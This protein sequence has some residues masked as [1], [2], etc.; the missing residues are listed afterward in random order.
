LGA[1]L[2]LIFAAC[3]D[4]GVESTVTDGADTTT[5]GDEPDVDTGA[6]DVVTPPP[7][8]GTDTGD[9]DIVEPDPDVPDPDVPDVPPLPECG[10]AA[11]TLPE[12]LIE[13]QHSDDVDG[14]ATVAAQTWTSTD[15]AIP[16]ATTSLYEAMRFELEHPGKIHGFSIQYGVLPS[17]PK[18]PVV[19]GLYPDFGNNG[20][21]FWQKDPYWTGSLC[22]GEITAGEWATYVF[23][24]PI[25]AEH[26]MLVYVA[27]HR[28]GDDDA[29]ISFGSTTTN[30]DGSCGGWGDCNASL[31]MPDVHTF[32]SGGQGNYAWN[33]LS[34]PFQYDFKI[35]LYVEY[36]DD[37]SSDDG[38]FQPLEEGPVLSNRTAWG[39][40]D[41]DGDADIYTAN[42]KL[43]RNDD[44]VF[45][46]VTEASGVGAATGNGGVWGDFDNDGCLDLFVFREGGKQNDTL[47]RS[48]CDDTWTDIT[49]E[50]GISD[51]QWYNICGDAEYDHA[52]T[53]AA[54]WWD[55]DGDGLLDLYLANMICWSD[56]TF[57]ND[58]IWHNEGDNTFTEWTGKNGFP[59]Y[60]DT[61]RSS[62]GANPIDA[63]QDGDVDMLVNRYTLHQNAYYRNNGDGT[64]TEDGY[65]SNLHGK[66][67]QWTGSVHYGH[68]IGTAWGDIDND[69]DFD[70]IVAN[71]AHPRFFNFSNKTQVMINDGQGEW[72][73]TQGDYKYP[74][75]D[76]GVRFSE[77]HSVP[78]L[79]DYDQNGSLDLVITA[80]YSGRPTDFYWGQGDG[81]FK[82]DTYHSGLTL[83]GAWGLAQADYDHD[84]DLDL[85]T[86]AGLYQNTG[87]EKG[88]WLQARAIGNVKSNRAALG[89]T[90]RL[91]IGEA[92]RVG[93]VSGGNGQG[94]QDSPNVH[95]GL[96]ETDS[97]DSIEVDFPGGGTITYAGPFAVDQRIW[98]FEDGATHIGWTPP[99]PDTE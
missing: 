83:T 48:N 25:E 74:T 78:A 62:R 16:L 71:L 46:D 32:T 90:I 10:E 11:G 98:L 72:N 95:F 54:A 15:A 31:T 67:K 60:T 47:L 51:L 73:D 97:V 43:F 7:D 45:V 86:S 37:F 38:L 81:T 64:V 5:T 40:Y 93:Y 29:A 50:S 66:K 55:I 20:F 87:T 41:G 88:H 61:A 82:L 2:G 52:P 91:K 68:S 58:Q 33:G 4:D 89:A 18:M 28:E 30:A 49:K 12:G 70:V 19:A 39:D 9:E 22:S 53:P 23:D 75:G 79:G 92:T 80:T 26:P 65:E 27:H 99:V 85:A 77:T 6:E 84:G 96:G 56:Y 57:F 8:E 94:G 17:N 42:N 3:G 1:C 35:R 76:A 36:T 59:G 21:D 24:A 63:D 34:F 14:L 44:G 13:L 69:G